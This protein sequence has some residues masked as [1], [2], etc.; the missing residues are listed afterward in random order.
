MEPAAVSSKPGTAVEK[1][2][3]VKFRVEAIGNLQSTK[4]TVPH[5]GGTRSVVEAKTPEWPGNTIRDPAGLPDTECARH[6]AI[7]TKSC[8]KS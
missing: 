2:L 4:V 6:A 8:V 7:K 5:V 3:F 1:I